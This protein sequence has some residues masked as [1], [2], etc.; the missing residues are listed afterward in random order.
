VPEP[1]SQR[2]A[3]RGVA[4]RGR[5]SARTPAARSRALPALAI[6]LLAAALYLPG[7][8]NGFAYDAVMLVEEDSRVHSLERP[9]R[10]LASSYWPGGEETLAL[11]RPL[12]TLSFATD[13][14][15]FGGAPAG[16]HL[17]TA[18]AHAA[19]SVL[20]FLLLAGLVSTPAAF[21][22]AALFAVHPVQTE[23]VASIVGRADIYA[24]GLCFAALLAWSRLPARSTALRVAVPALFLLALGSK[25]SAI[26][27]P[28]LLVLLDAAAGRI[29]RARLREWLRERAW[30]LAGMTLVAISYLA[31]RA[32]VLGG[33]A[34]QS[35]NPIMAAI[36]SGATRLRSALQVWPEILRLFVF[37]W[38]LLADYGPRILMPAGSWTPRALTGFALLAGAILGG[39]LALVRG[40]GRTGFALLWTPIALLPVSNLILPIGVL[41]AERTLYIATFALAL[42]VALGVDAVAGRPRGLRAALVACAIAGTL[43][44]TR[45]VLRLP[46]W[47]STDEV[48]RTLLRDR[49]DSYRAHWHHARMAWRDGDP[50]AAAGFY[51]STLELW[52]YA[53]PVFLE[54]G[55]FASETGRERDARAFAEQGLGHWPDD[56]TLLRRL[57]VACLNLSDTTAARVALERGLRIAPDDPLFLALKEAIGTA[58][59]R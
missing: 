30:P 36:P 34:P 52:P 9:A 55:L 23:A 58:R 1:A 54:A 56:A 7:I 11:Y 24:A 17:S 15:L 50:E 19:A 32:A 29:S 2:A 39:V 18:L 21:A 43:F 46:S 22:G 57:A 14:A 45:T 20:L 33:L 26:V 59:P 41:L 28:A 5:A 49:P 47:R 53:R 37:P 38:T 48:F 6:A 16:F 51:R 25:E 4:A 3:T 35:L 10:L 44:A 31:A 8:R 12:V 27:L 42:G 13:W 40:R